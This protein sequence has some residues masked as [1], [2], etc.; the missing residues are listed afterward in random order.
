MKYCYF[1]VTVNSFQIY[2]KIKDLYIVYGQRLPYAVYAAIC[3]YQQHKYIFDIFT[4]DI[5]LCLCLLW[6]PP[7]MEKVMTFEYSLRKYFHLLTNFMHE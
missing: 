5:G 6:I 3:E 4:A 1:G 2:R 7:D